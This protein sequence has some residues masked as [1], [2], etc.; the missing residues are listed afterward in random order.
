MPQIKV[1]LGVGIS[2]AYQYDILDIDED[3]W[4][5][6]TTDEE[7]EKLLEEYAE[8]WAGNYIDLGYTLIE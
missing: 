4:N 7:R 8:E 6:C 3:S 1:T 2:N 5:A